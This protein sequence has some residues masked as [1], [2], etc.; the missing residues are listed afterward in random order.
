VGGTAGRSYSPSAKVPPTEQPGAADGEGGVAVGD[1]VRQ[2][3][4]GGGGDGDAD[5]GTK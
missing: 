2:G 3:A 1:R 5:L 4:P